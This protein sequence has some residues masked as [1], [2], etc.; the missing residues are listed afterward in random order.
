MSEP[1]GSIGIFDSGFGG[2]D[3]FRGIAAE[4]PEY[5]YSYLAD[6]ARAPYGPRSSE[7]VYEYTRQAVDFLFARGAV[8]IILACNT[9][10]SEAL[11]KLQ[12]QYLPEHHPGKNVLGVLIPAAEQAVSVSASGRIGVIATE[13]TVR[14]ETFPAELQKLRPDVQVFQNPAPKLVP[15]VEAGLQDSEEAEQALR[16]YLEPLLQAGI[17]ALILGCTHYGILEPL[18][19]KIVGPEL[20]IVSEARV[21]PAKLRTYLLRHPEIEAQLARDKTRHFSTTDATGRFERIGSQLLGQL[22]NSEVVVLA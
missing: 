18:I 1:K 2:L 4:L 13:G 14:S 22:L 17:D 9:A 11:R 21:V 15:L 10:S 16:E 20:A 19:Q 6:S 12:Q 7:E 5:S 8:L 3:I